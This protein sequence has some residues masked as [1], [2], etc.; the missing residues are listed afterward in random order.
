MGSIDTSRASLLGS[1][2]LFTRTF[3]KLRTGNDFIVS[4]PVGRQSHHID[5]C[6]ALTRVSKHEVN[7]LIINCPPRYGKSELC[8]HFIAWMLARYPD[9]NFMY[10]SYSLSLAK[11]QTQ[12]IRDIMS[13][14][15]YKEIFGVEISKD[16]SAKDNFETN[17]GGSV[18][19]CGSGGTVTGRGAGIQGNDRRFGGAI[20]I[21]DIHKPSEVLSDTIR[22]STL[23]WHLNTLQSR[24]N[25]P[26]VPII[27]IGQRVHEDDHTA[28]LMRGYDG[29]TW[30][31]LTLP[32]IDVCGNALDPRLHTLDDLK[33]MSE[34]M[35]YEFSAQYQQEPA[36]AGG[37]IFKREWFVLLD[38]MPKMIATFITAD[39]AET[40]KTYNDASVFSFWGIYKI[41][42]FGQE[43]DKYGIHWIDCIE[44]RMEPKDLRERFL[45]FYSECFRFPVKPHLIAIE[46]KST[47]T[48]LVSTLQDLRGVQIFPI[49][50]TNILNKSQRFLNIQYYVA[51]KL[52]S[53]NA[54]AK[55]TRNCI[56]HMCK[57]TPNQTQ[58]FDDIA[59]TLADAVTLMYIDNMVVTTAKKEQENKSVSDNLSAHFNRQIQVG[60]QLW[61]R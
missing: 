48:T 26:H 27:A 28:N 3:Y 24:V 6:R 55:H 41:V 12:T 19:A 33:K 8:I 13:L 20:V 58:R 56:E 30:E 14:P 15:E 42:E 40:D 1:L 16:S 22:Q 44:E 25:G 38:E 23:D 2:L 29:K 50:R 17:Y 31:R 32:A 21:D 7:R 51:S 18:Y 5:I 47:G 4:E 53:L 39:T 52:V 54:D 11:R 34:V 35:S 45:K 10:V 61:H 57:I 49:E 37:G 43:T 59:D 60:R 46:K 9:S 36:P